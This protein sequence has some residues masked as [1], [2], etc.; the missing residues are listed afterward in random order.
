M[1]KSQE[2]SGILLS[3]VYYKDSDAIY[4]FLTDSEGRISVYAR[5]VRK[6]DSKMANFL[7]LG[8][9]L[10][11][12]VKSGKNLAILSSVKSIFLPEG[13]TYK[14]LIKLQEILNSSKA[15]CK[16]GISSKKIYDDLKDVILFFKEF[17][18]DYQHL[19]FLIKSL[20]HLGFL[21][22]LRYCSKTQKALVDGQSAFFSNESGICQER[23]PYSF[24][25]N[26]E[27]LKTLNFLQK[28]KVKDITKLENSEKYQ[29][30][31]ELVLK[32]LLEEYS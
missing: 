32:S 24:E 28:A 10:S 6:K 9:V 20:S 14:Q 16:Q 21:S 23:Q 31:L 26:F 22:D 19:A 3:R 30:E 8:S 13:F 17:R 25:L 1:Q 29:G 7:N 15:I 5:G 4:D 11:L 18:G 27:T 2:L 12:D